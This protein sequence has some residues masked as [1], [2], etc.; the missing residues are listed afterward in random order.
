MNTAATATDY[1]SRSPFFGESRF[2]D[3]PV[4]LVVLDRCVP[5]ADAKSVVEFHDITTARYVAWGG[6][7][8]SMIV[9]PQSILAATYFP[10]GGLLVAGLG[11]VLA[12]VGL[13][14]PRVKTAAIVL[15]A[16]VATLSWSALRL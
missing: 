3:P 6:V 5:A 1:Q 4:D 15:V 16:H 2:V 11:C 7:I 12:I 14:S 9:V 13:S 8:A 10:A